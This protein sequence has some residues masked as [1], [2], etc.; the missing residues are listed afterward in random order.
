MKISSIG[1]IISVA[2]LSLS[3]CNTIR[4]WWQYYDGTVETSLREPT[5]YYEHVDSQAGVDRLVVPASLDEPIKDRTLDVP[6]ATGDGK[7]LIGSEMDI[8]APIVPVASDMGITGQYNSNE[9]IIW[10]NRHGS[11]GIYT[12]DAAFS[13]LKKVLA[14][15]NVGIKS[16]SDTSYELETA[17][18]DYNENGER[19]DSQYDYVNALRYA[20]IYRLRIGRDASGNLGIATALVASKTMLPNGVMLDNTLSRVELQRFATGFSN[21]IIKELEYQAQMQ[22]TIPDEVIVTLDRDNNDEIALLVNAPYEVTFNVLKDLIPKYGM[23]IT[24]YSISH[25]T[26]NFDVEEDDPDFYRELGVDPFLLDTDSYII[27]VGVVGDKTSITF[28]DEDDKPLPESVVN[29]L[30]SGFSSALVKEFKIYRSQGL[31]N[32][33]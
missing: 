8:R 2:V 5:G 21:S 20:Q 26:F 7:S 27:R 11:H 29:R 19:Y 25:S 9:A 1:A 33:L 3:G 32:G 13:L 23:V 14:D 18:A 6:M 10:F 22:E 4:Y 16:V 17:V 30:Y 28:Y 24:E 31:N 15:I 12:E